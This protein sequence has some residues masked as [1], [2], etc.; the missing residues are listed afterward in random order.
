MIG[1]QLLEDLAKKVGDPLVNRYEI[2]VGQRRNVREV[3]N[4][5][6][7]EWPYLVPE[8]H[9]MCLEEQPQAQATK[10]IVPEPSAETMN[11]DTNGIE[12]VFSEAFGHPVHEDLLQGPPFRPQNLAFLAKI[13]LYSG[14]ETLVCLNRS[15]GHIDK[16][17]EPHSNKD[18]GR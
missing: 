13:I 14:V 2:R 17:V 18:A 15:A 5:T 1:A 9:V 16:V 3:R 10:W 11:V 7:L 12:F 4:I 8:S 6:L